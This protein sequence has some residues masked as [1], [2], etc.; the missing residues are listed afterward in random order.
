MNTM[1]HLIDI[2]YRF[3]GYIFYVYFKFL[4]NFEILT[5]IF[6]SCK[7][8]RILECTWKKNNVFYKTKL[9]WAEL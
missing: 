4:K 8:K 3:S 7:K 2:L 5:K 6:N 9:Q 1:L